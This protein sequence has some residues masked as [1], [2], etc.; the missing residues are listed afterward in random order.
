MQVSLVSHLGISQK[1]EKGLE[2]G[3]AQPVDIMADDAGHENNYAANGEP[4]V[5]FM[6][7]QQMVNRV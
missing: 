4:G 2:V 6:I 7:M 3:N 5:V 1:I